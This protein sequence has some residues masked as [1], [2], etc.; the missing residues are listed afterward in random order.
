MAIIEDNDD[1]I[2]LMFVLLGGYMT[3]YVTLFIFFVLL[4]VM[5]E[6]NIHI[7]FNRYCVINKQRVSIMG[8]SLLF[9]L[10]VFRLKTVG[11][12]LGNYE[13]FFRSWLNKTPTI[14]TFISHSDPLFHF[15]LWL[16]GTLTTNFQIVVCL[17]T[18][19]TL[20][21]YYKAILAFSDNISFSLLLFIG[22]GRIRGLYSGIRQ[23]LAVAI[24]LYSYKYIKEKR[25]IP[26][27]ICWIIAS[28][29]HQTAIVTI[30]AY[31][32]G[33]QKRISNLI[34]EYAVLILGFL[35]TTLFFIPW[36]VSLYKTNNYQNRIV[37]GQGEVLL[38][39]EVAIL[40][41]LIWQVGTQR[42][43]YQETLIMLRIYGICC[44]F[45]GMALG[46]SL[47]NR[48]SYY[49]Y[50]TLIILVPNVISKMSNKFNRSVMMLFFIV[51]YGIIFYIETSANTSGV[52]PYRFMW[53]QIK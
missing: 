33:G 53:Q 14:I 16:I 24:M 49:F 3:F 18:T 29:I 52:I 42:K 11:G 20:S 15:G 45:Q 32:I 44:L 22:M 37:A 46:F 8:M 1:V 7:S 31:F 51:L 43:V 30:V 48:L 4:T 41:L 21:V 27:L 23:E 38:I 12:D 5:E 39:I 25:I 50:V 36:I 35:L 19:I 17:I 9:F 26:F 2:E 10:S 28:L 34:I 47:A 13:E 40:F 6:K